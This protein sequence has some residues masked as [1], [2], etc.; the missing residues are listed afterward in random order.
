M[1]SG[2]PFLTKNVDKFINDDY[3]FF[4]KKNYHYLAVIKTKALP[5]LFLS[6]HNGDQFHLNCFYN[7]QSDE[8][9][10]RSEK[11]CKNRKYYKVKI[12]KKFM[13][14]FNNDTNSSALLRMFQ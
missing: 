7:F 8:I 9:L 13:S 14:I 10:K 4:E 6:K 12:P 3:E 1:K 5:R 2:I 11:V